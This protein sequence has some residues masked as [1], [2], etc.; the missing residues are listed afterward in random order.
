MKPHIHANNSARKWKGK[1]QDYMPIHNEMDCTKS[2]MPDVRHRAVYHSAFGIYL[3]EK[4]F[5]E[6]ITNSDG[7]VVSV[8][9]IAEQH[10]TEDLGFIPTMQDWLSNMKIQPWMIRPAVRKEFGIKE[11]DN[12]EPEVEEIPKPLNRPNKPRPLG[13]RRTLL[14]SGKVD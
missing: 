13:G 9:D 7:R 14:R 6:V 4:I 2:A 12:L 1:P 11:G 10:V 3:I 5:G 8:R